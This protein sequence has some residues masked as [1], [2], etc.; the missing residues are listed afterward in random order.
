MEIYKKENLL[1]M[2]I[3]DEKEFLKELVSLCPDSIIGVNREGVIV[4]FNRAAE[5]LTQYTGEEVIGKLHIIEIYDSMELARLIK[6]RLYSPEF[7]PPGQ[8][9]GLEIEI[10]DRYRHKIPIRLS[11]TLIFK[12]GQEVGSVGFFHDL[13]FKR[14]MEDKLRELSVT[15]SLSGLFNQR[16]FYANLTAEMEKAQAKKYPLS[17]ICFDI[18]NFKE[19][20]D[21]L[22]H[23]EG[24]NIIR[25]IGQTLK[26][27]LRRTDMGFRY[28]GDEFMVLLPG[29]DITGANFSAE[30]IRKR[31][32]EQ[33]CFSSFCDNTLSKKI[34]LSMGIAQFNPGESATLFVKRA[35]M[36]M[37]EAKR[38]GGNK[39][40]E[41]GSQI[42]KSDVCPST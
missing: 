42:G 18:D 23:L 13:T 21:R 36:A 33:A 20:N 26:Q 35:D 14:Q 4:I 31:F 28:G 2:G 6:K 34:S 22:G 27:I 16:H 3:T 10:S 5:K 19:C 38:A 32:N 29:T 15:D 17:L 37:Y 39:T 30:R 25:M 12:E 1:K 8:I 24:D 9:E 41:A 11:A 7:G 40:V